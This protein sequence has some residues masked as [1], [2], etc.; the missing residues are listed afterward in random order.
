MIARARRVI[1]FGG[2]FIPYKAFYD[3]IMDSETFEEAMHLRP[4]KMSNT[5]ASGITI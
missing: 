1:G 3:K 5:V 2:A 4:A